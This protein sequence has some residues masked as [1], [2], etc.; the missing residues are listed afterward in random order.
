MPSIELIFAEFG[1]SRYNNGDAKLPLDRLEPSLS[2]FMKYFPEAT[3]TVYTDQ[4]WPDTDRYRVAKVDPPFDRSHPR[5]GNRAND[6]YDAHGLLES[7]ADVAIALDSDLVVVSDRVQD[8]IP[9]AQ[10]FGLCM[11]VN[12]RHLVYRDARS[13]CDGG[14]VRDD[15][16]GSAMCHCTALWA[17]SEETE[18][19]HRML[20]EEYLVQIVDDAQRNTGARGPLSLWRAQWERRLAPYTLPSHYCVT[21]S[22]LWVPAEDAIVL[23]VG[24]QAV[25]THYASLLT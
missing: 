4:D 22:N 24:H 7:S 2:S 17:F 14:K 9:L 15:T 6:Y 13:D 5:Y 23:H 11:P 20:L 8:L 18:T 12:G 1:E 25:Q 3:A 16:H 10:H 19:G 21:G